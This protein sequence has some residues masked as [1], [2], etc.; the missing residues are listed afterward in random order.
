MN[1]CRAGGNRGS[2]SPTVLRAN[3]WETDVE[4]LL[5]KEEE[6]RDYLRRSPSVNSVD[7]PSQ[8]KD[9]SKNQREDGVSPVGV[10]VGRERSHVSSDEEEEEDQKLNRDT[11][12]V[13][14]DEG[15]CK[16]RLYNE[17][18]QRADCPVFY[19]RK[20]TEM[21]AVRN[22]E[23]ELR[24]KMRGRVDLSEKV[25]RER[26]PERWSGSGKEPGESSSE[27]IDSD[28]DMPGNPTGAV[29]NITPVCE[30]GRF[31][32][33]QASLGAGRT[34]DPE[35][36]GSKSSAGEEEQEESVIKSER[37]TKGVKRNQNRKKIFSVTYLHRK[38][39]LAENK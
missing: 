30:V 28:R 35:T 22:P 36:G 21:C 6:R 15:H 18:G 20:S 23:N 2:R 31:G 19:H 24:K 39:L 29:S 16:C 10:P 7:L 25:W 37:E 14:S 9:K 33:M 4:A 26:S 8:E 12:P 34:A 17:A 27:E 13:D 32:M 38:D 3:D 11:S 5:D 1:Q